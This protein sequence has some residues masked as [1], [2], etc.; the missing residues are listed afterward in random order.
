MIKINVKKYDDF[1]DKYTKRYMYIENTY[2]YFKNSS[3]LKSLCNRANYNRDNCFMELESC[4]NSICD[5]GRELIEQKTF[6]NIFEID[7]DCI[8]NY[9]NIYMLVYQWLKKNPFPYNYWAL[10]DNNFMDKAF[11]PKNAIMQFVYD[12][13]VCHCFHQ[14]NSMLLWLQDD[15]DENVVR[16]L[17]YYLDYVNLEKMY[18]DTLDSPYIIDLDLL[19]DETDAEHDLK[20][21]KND[22]EMKCSNIAFYESIN[23][24]MIK[25]ISYIVGYRYDEFLISSEKPIYLYKQEKYSLIETCRSTIG[26]SYYQ[27]LLNLTSS[28]LPYNAKRCK[29]PNCSIMF[30]SNY[31]QDYCNKPECR[32]YRNNKKSYDNYH[33]KKVKNKES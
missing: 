11:E 24:I 2:T 7:V 6:N 27:L 18:K 5:L 33:R 8:K 16:K 17:K 14:I 12:S 26:I 21:L 20:Q 9:K 29:N 13:I 19:Y 32:K 31:R 15:Y 3:S 1:D 25:I 10:I 4:F 23:R 22:I 28:N 30:Q